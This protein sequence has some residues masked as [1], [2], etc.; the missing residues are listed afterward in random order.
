MALTTSKLRALGLALGA[1]AFIT[2][3]LLYLYYPAIPHSAFGWAAL[4]VVG[5]PTWIALEL[6][7]EYALGRPFFAKLSS[8][9]R[10]AVA[11]PIVIALMVIGGVLVHY[12]QKVITAW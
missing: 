6:F 5:I 1:I 7:G 9:A 8:G 2:C 4:F 12:G 10:I 3:A 11:V